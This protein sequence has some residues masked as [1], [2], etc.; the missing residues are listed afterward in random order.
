MSLGVAPRR[1]RR[2]KPRFL[3]PQMRC[4]IE[5]IVSMIF[6]MEKVFHVAGLR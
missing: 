4:G 6:L 1:A 3:P 2:Q 5:K